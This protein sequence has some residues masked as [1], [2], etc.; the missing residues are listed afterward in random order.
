[1]LRHSSFDEKH[2]VSNNPEPATSKAQSSP[3]V[4]LQQNWKTTSHTPPLVHSVCVSSSHTRGGHSHSPI[5]AVI[6]YEQ[7]SGAASQTSV[8]SSS[9]EEFAQEIVPQLVGQLFSSLGV[10]L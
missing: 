9:C 10:S 1:M 3:F 5:S 8:H 6:S 4:S 2:S 7:P